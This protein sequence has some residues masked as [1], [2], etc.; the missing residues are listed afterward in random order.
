MPF[1]NL[2]QNHTYAQNWLEN[3][4][5]NQVIKKDLLEKH[6]FLDG[7]SFLKCS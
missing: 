4:N 2:L 7:A 3:P 5:K 1:M 6:V